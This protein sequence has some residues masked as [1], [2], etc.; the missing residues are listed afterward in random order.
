ME[1]GTHLEEFVWPVGGANAELLQQLHHEPTEALERPWQPHLHQKG[2]PLMTLSPPPE[3]SVYH[4]SMDDLQ[5]THEQ[6]SRGT[7]IRF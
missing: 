7:H 2:Y 1:K 5:H 3:K 4:L 6:C